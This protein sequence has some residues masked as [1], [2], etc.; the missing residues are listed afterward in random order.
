MDT[1]ILSVDEV[2]RFLEAVSSLTSLASRSF[3]WMARPVGLSA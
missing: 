2:V 1:D 3:W